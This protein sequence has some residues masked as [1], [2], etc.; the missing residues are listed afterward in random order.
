MAGRPSG[1]ITACALVLAAANNLL[2]SR[3]KNSFESLSNVELP[4]KEVEISMAL[5]G[6]F[7][8]LYSLV[9]SDSDNLALICSAPLNSHQTSF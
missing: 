8:A 4:G 7:E 2:D 1:G 5:G 9:S 6:L 3:E